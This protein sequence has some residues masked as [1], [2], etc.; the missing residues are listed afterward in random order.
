MTGI[1]PAILNL[2]TA[3]ELQETADGWLML[4]WEQVIETALDW[5]ETTE[6]ISAGEF[7]PRAG[8]RKRFWNARRHLLNN[9]LLLCQQAMELDLKARIAAA[10]P[11]ELVVGKSAA[12]LRQFGGNFLEASTIGARD[13]PAAVERIGKTKLDGAYI[14]LF[15]RLRVERNRIA[16]LHGGNFPA[17]VRQRLE[18]VLSVFA[19]IHPGERW[20]AFCKANMTAN[21]KAGPLAD[22]DYDRT[23]SR[24]LREFEAAVNVLDTAGARRHFG[25]D[26]RKPVLFCPRCWN[27]RQ[28]HDSDERDFAQRQSNGK[29]TCGACLAMYPNKAAY[30]SECGEWDDESEGEGN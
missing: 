7:K 8:L 4:A 22:H 15:E 5:D 12:K 25:F 16:H 27:E 28:K 19:V 30:N 29:I 18:D 20:Q 6:Y 11:L 26:K 2:P 13:L 21:G 17:H 24:W 3:T 9:S 14:A 10:D 23:H 1:T